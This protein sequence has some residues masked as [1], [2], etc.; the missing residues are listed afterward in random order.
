[1]QELSFYLPPY[2][3]GLN[4]IGGFAELKAFIE[5]GWGAYEDNPGQGFDT[6]LEWCVDAVGGRE[7]L[8]KYS[9]SKHQSSYLEEQSVLHN[10]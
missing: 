6:F 3:P 2:S 5:K 9:R 8:L 4:P 7:L 1:M 10:L